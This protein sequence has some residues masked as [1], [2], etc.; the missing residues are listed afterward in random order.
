[1]HVS[2]EAL[3]PHLL[4]LLSGWHYRKLY[5]EIS[6]RGFRKDEPDSGPRETSQVLHKVRALATTSLTRTSLLPD[7]PTIAESGLAGFDVTVWLGL[8]APAG[9]PAAVLDRLHGES[10]KILE[11]KDIR[12]K[13]ANLGME[14]IGNSP[15]EFAAVIK[16][17]IPFW[18]DV[19]RRAGIRP[20]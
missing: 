9:T 12:D 20:E 5:I 2:T 8:L 6:E 13:L 1:V 18:A 17:E 16:S 4:A 10:V 3:W 11:M 14:L 15:E 7:V 19:I